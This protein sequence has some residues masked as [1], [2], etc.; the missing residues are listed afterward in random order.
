MDP[1]IP[2][3]AATTLVILAAGCLTGQPANPGA[4]TLPS[5]PAGD[6]DRI[7]SPSDDL[8]RV[9][10]A[11]EPCQR[12]YGTTHNRT[13]LEDYRVAHGTVHPT[14]T[15]AV[16]AAAGDDADPVWVVTGEDI[17]DA[18]PPDQA[19]PPIV[20]PCTTTVRATLT[21]RSATPANLGLRY[22]TAA[23]QTGEPWQTTDRSTTPCPDR[24]D[25]CRRYVIQPSAHKAD[26]STAQQSRWRFGVFAEDTLAAVDYAVRLNLSTQGR[27]PASC[28]EAPPGW[29]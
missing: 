6:D 13:L 11:V 18:D 17:D 19:D 3:V 2:F 10:R 15:E 23:D 9:C 21:W 28:A 12:F 5:S 14:G 16:Q 20:P 4:D 8:V 1:Q 29:C 25:T 7:C 27:V 24:P 26:R 22:H